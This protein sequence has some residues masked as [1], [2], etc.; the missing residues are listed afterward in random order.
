MLSLY[1]LS[2]LKNPVVEQYEVSNEDSIN[3][4]APVAVVGGVTIECLLRM[5]HKHYVRGKPKK[6]YYECW[7]DSMSELINQAGSTEGE[8]LKLFNTK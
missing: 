3:E 8:F 1:N 5:A 6:N 7:A 2:D 4:A